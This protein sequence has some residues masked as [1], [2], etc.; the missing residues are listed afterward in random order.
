MKQRFPFAIKLGLSFAIVIL[1][2]VALVYFFT[3]TGIT[4]RFATFSEQNKQQIARQVCSLLGEYRA[5]T[6][7]WIGVN[8]LLSSQQTIL[9]GGKLI[10]RRT[11]LIPGSFSLA[12][13][14]GTVFISTEQGQVGITLSPTQMDEGIPIEANNA[15]VG[16]L[17]LDNV[18]TSLAPAEEEFLA[19]AKRSALL[20]GAIAF[21]LALLLSVLLISEV[22]SPLRVLTRATEQIARGDLTQRVKLKARDEFGQ[23]GD[24][25]NRMIKNLRHSEE[26]RRSMTADIA[27]ELRTPVT[28]IQGNL[29]AILDEIYEPT[30]DTI[31]PI[32]EETLRLGQLID[33]LRDIS[34]AEAKELQLNIE[35]I[36]VV[37]SIKQLVETISASLDQGPQIRVEANST[38]PQVPVDL[39]RFQQVLVNLLT[40]ALRFTPQQGTIHIQVLRKDQEVEVRVADSGPGIS[41][42]EIPHLFER[43]YRGDQARSRGQG[44][45][46][47]GLAISKQLIEA[48]GGRIWAENDP[49][50]GAIFVIRLPLA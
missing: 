32:Y 40:N 36:Q 48:H 43:F 30:T 28:I 11:F 27:H 39:K 23:L 47:L 50:G 15:R 2:S 5:R 42:E 17:L 26:I 25:F 18:G 8:Q 16:T 46:G 29:E 6:G 9:V 41:P 21:G 14:Q 34:L 37:A 22:L 33:D 24:S 35:P 45:S 31:A 7:N 4:T 1:V 3:A 10:V 20:G 44:G 49:S 12:N 38:I 19:S 13:E